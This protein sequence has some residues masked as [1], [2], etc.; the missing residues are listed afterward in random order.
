MPSQ[1][2][3]GFQLFWVRREET[4]EQLL[5]QTRILYDTWDAAT[6]AAKEMA[7]KEAEDNEYCQV[8]NKVDDLSFSDCLHFKNTKLFLLVDD[9]DPH[10]EYG[11]VWVTPVFR[12]ETKL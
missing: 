3:L 1:T 2:L 5:Y 12:H 8:L 6:N 4:K 9:R 10:E 11:S 7:Y